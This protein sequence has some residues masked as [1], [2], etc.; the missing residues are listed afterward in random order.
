[1]QETASDYTVL[2]YNSVLGIFVRFSTAFTLSAL[3]WQKKQV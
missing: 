2:A 1:M 3:Q